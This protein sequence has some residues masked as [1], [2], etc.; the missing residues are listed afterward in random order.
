MNENQDNDGDK[1]FGLIACGGALPLEFVRHAHEHGIEK[2]AVAGLKDTTDPEVYQKSFCHEEMKLGEL[3]R[4]IKFFKKNGVRKAVMLGKIPPKFAVTD[5]PLDFRLIKLAAKILDRRA[6]GILSAIS[7]EIA[8]D[9]IIIQE[10]T[11]YLKHLL[12][13]EAILTKKHPDSKQ[14]IDIKLGIEIASAIGG[15]DIGQT[16]VVYKHAVI[17]VE[18]MEGT[19]DCI[20]RAGKYTKNTVI[21]KM[22]KPKQDFRFD[23]PCVGVGTVESMIEAGAKVL[24]VE[25]GKTFILEKEKTLDLA[26]SNGIVICGITRSYGKE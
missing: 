17:A 10:T 8:N 2:V 4:L 9:G 1:I 16:A 18:A 24:A 12:A 21:V 15:Y 14:E 19:D 25:A 7:D 5:I 26:N 13:P 23:V 20:R 22:A 11:R 6:D 3:S